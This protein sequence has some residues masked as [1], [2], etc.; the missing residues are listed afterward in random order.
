MH[1]CWNDSTLTAPVASGATVNLAAP[2]KSQALKVVP[3]LLVVSVTV[4][5]RMKKLKT[6][7]QLP[8]GLVLWIK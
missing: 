6:I 1:P 3:S 2:W 4:T 5:F 8:H 7:A